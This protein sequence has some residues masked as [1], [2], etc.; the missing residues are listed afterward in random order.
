MISDSGA[1]S[2][3]WLRKARILPASFQTGTMIDMRTGLIFFLQLQRRGVHAITEAG[4][5]WAIVEDVT[6]MTFAA[7]TQNLGAV[8]EKLAI[9]F[10]L[11]RLRR[12]RRVETRPAAARFVLRFRIKKFLTA[13]CALVN[14]LLVTVRILAGPGALRPLLA[15]D[16]VLHWGQLLFPLGVTLNDFFAHVRLTILPSLCGKTSFFVIVPR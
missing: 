14:A 15:Q 8:H 12:N 2:R 11:N 9:G 16:V 4:R 6:K 10:R 5:L 3:R 7:C 13:A 1:Q